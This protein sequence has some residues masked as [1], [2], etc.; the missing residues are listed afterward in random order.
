MEE[1]H[2]EPLDHAQLSWFHRH[3]CMV[4]AQVLGLAHQPTSAFTCGIFFFFS[5][6]EWLVCRVRLPQ[7]DL[8]VLSLCTGCVYFKISTNYFKHAWQKKKKNA[9]CT[10]RVNA[11]L[12]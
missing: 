6:L 9:V 12:L 3:V 10:F 11:K 8:M 1:T 2:S 5:N 7:Y 4:P